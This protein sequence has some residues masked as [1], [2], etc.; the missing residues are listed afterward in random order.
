MPPDRRRQI[1]ALAKSLASP[2]G[3]DWL[4]TA[5]R[6]LG[7][8]LCSAA[9]L[10]ASPK[11]RRFLEA[12]SSVWDAMRESLAGVPWRE[13]PDKDLIRLGL[14]GIKPLARAMAA[15]LG[16]AMPFG[17]GASSID[18]ALLQI[19]YYGRVAHRRDPGLRRLTLE[20]AF[21]FI[22]LHAAEE[23]GRRIEEHQNAALLLAATVAQRPPSGDSPSWLGGMA[24]L[25]E[26]A[27][28]KDYVERLAR[29]EHPKTVSGVLG[30]REDEAAR[31]EFRGLLGER[32]TEDLRRL[33]GKDYMDIAEDVLTGR[34]DYSHRSARQALLRGSSWA[35]RHA[36]APEEPEGSPDFRAAQEIEEAAEKVYLASAVTRAYRLPKAQAR[37]IEFVVSQPTPLTQEIIAEGAGVSLATVKLTIRKIAGEKA[38]LLEILSPR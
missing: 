16:P 17:L 22:G 25:I 9:A 12:A 24:K 3:R 21:T 7:P 1:E 29:S 13:L 36:A 35:R 31:K 19:A 10:F 5:P 30:E 26:N 2:N 37:V 23:F 20:I 32:L 34:M 6:K 11:G 28:S 8:D 18:P 14:S 4:A 33:S 15:F 38:R 27:A